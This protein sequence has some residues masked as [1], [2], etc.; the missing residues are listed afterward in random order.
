MGTRQL[1]AGE[2]ATNFYSNEYVEFTLAIGCPVNCHKYCPQEVL[3][4]NY[5]KNER[6]MSLE[7]FKK[8]LNHIPKNV[9]IDFSGFCE[10]CV[11]PYFTDMAKYAHQEGYRIHVATTL[12]YATNKAVKD[13]LDLPYE[14]FVLHLPDG[15]NA[16]F[17]LTSEFKENIFCIMQGI[18]NVQ[19]ITMND[20]FISNERENLC[21][22]IL[23]K[24]RRVGFCR[25]TVTPQLVVMPDGRVQTCD[26][27]FKL[28]HT[29]GNLLH[30]EYSTIVK[31]FRDRQASFNLCHYCKKYYSIDRY[32]IYKIAGKLGYFNKSKWM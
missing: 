8:M 23:P 14:G 2:R 5:G 24:P 13:L 27:D 11:N 21:R 19:Y 4:K 31:R 32:L 29:V 22:G 28:E 9:M 30:N 3:L 18:P 17:Q 15:K 20:L 12:Q 7:S 25:K 1:S 26:M 10:P 16:N 6:L